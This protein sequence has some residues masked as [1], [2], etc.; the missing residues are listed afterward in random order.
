MED[1]KSLKAGALVS[2]QK[3]KRINNGN[4]TEWSAIWSEIILVISK[5]NERAAWVRFEITSM[6]SDQNCTTWSLSTTLL[7]PLILE[8]IQSLF[9]AKIQGYSQYQHFIDPVG[10]KSCKIRHTMVFFVFRFPAIWLVTWNKPW[11]LI[12]CFVLVFLSH[13]LGKWRDLEQ[14]IVRFGNKSHCWEPIRL[15]GSAVISKWMYNV[16][17]NKHRDSN[18]QPLK[19]C[20]EKL[21]S[22]ESSLHSFLSLTGTFFL[23]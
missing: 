8:I 16:I 1:E 2:L 14:K 4:W 6:I 5:S 22:S 9:I 3:D 13:W 17:K 15:Q 10:N 18:G 12:G 20:R 19:I 11:N 23:N 21:F 7:P